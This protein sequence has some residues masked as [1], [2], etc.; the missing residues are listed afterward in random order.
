LIF[1]TYH[2]NGQVF[3]ARGKIDQSF[4]EI[5]NYKA[6]EKG[7]YKNR[8]EKKFTQEIE[9]EMRNLLTS[10]KVIYNCEA[11]EFIEKVANKLLKNQEK[12]RSQ[13]HFYVVRS[14]D[15]NAFTYNNGMIFIHIGLLANLK[16]EAQLAF[17][18]AHEISHYQLNHTFEKYKQTKI[19]RK[20]AEK[21]NE[22]N[23]DAFLS[24]MSYSREKELEADKNGL[25]LFLASE[26][27]TPAILDVFEM[28]AFADFPFK[29][30]P[31][32]R[33]NFE[34][35]FFKISPLVFP[36][37]SSSIESEG[38]SNNEFATH[39]NIPT[40]I[41]ELKNGFNDSWEK[42]ADFLV[43]ESYF[44]KIKKEALIELTNIFLEEKNYI[45]CFYHCH[46]LLELNPKNKLILLNE[47]KA[48]FFIQNYLNQDERSRITGSKKKI[49][50]EIQK[51]YFFFHNAHKSDMNAFV[52][53]WSWK[54]R[55]QFPND[56]EIIKYSNLC[57]KEFGNHVSKYY[58]HFLPESEYNDSLFSL[59]YKPVEIKDEPV[60]QVESINKFGLK[61]FKYIKKLKSTHYSISHFAVSDNLNDSNFKKVFEEQNDF[62]QQNQVSEDAN[63]K[64]NSEVK[65]IT[66]DR[67]QDLL[68][69]DINNLLFDFRLEDPLKF[70]AVKSKQFQLKNLIIETGKLNGIRVTVLNPMEL[71]SD[72]SALFAEKVILKKWINDRLDDAFYKYDYDDLKNKKEIQQIMKKY[73]ST[74]I[75]FINSIAAMDQKEIKTND[76]FYLILSLFAPPLPLYVGY[77][78]F[79]PIKYSALY[80]PIYNLGNGDL[81]Y[82]HEKR[83]R[84]LNSIDY[85]RS[86]FYKFF[87]FISKY[88]LY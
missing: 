22:D 74:H 79:N 43:D 33:E 72:D 76:Y 45:N 57:I 40:R 29:N 86:E 62:I 56:M 64:Q 58:E 60:E 24:L 50:G 73:N 26:Y 70:Q 15:I 38:E 75:C 69:I 44:N 20:R 61:T 49:K 68:A 28:L 81:I 16:S 55:M 7:I 34:T 13:V 80:I 9:F 47:L 87:Y 54:I 37:T 59:N 18:L 41:T 3:Q 46:V 67:I 10:G 84:D 52:L 17:I 71:N 53:R 8:V 23:T 31:I 32:H 66:K 48:L 51:L 2:S 4:L 11:S 14:S 39:P 77:T 65:P 19:E 12:L 85:T 25:K 78:M 88:E 21:S 35:P 83:F 1:I 82:T 42:G 5:L 27:A 30:R 36:D 63:V 6:S